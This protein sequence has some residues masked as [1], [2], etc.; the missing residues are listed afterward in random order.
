MDDIHA[1]LKFWFEDIE[2]SKWWIQDTVFDEEIR[3]RFLT[4]HQK[5]TRCEL[6]AWRDTPE[7]AL[8]EI[9][10]LDQFSRNMFRGQPQSFAWDPLA[11]A[12]AQSAIR[13]QYDQELDAAR[14]LFIYMPFMHSESR[15]I[16]AVAK[17]LFAQEGLENNEKFEIEH[18]QII[19]RFGRYPHRNRVLGRQSTPDE[20]EFLHAPIK[21]DY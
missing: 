18:K 17:M 14:R 4:I 10:V 15:E 8:A 6:D 16:H 9:I 13:L 1:I 2:S 3:R 7:G 11:L 12:L 5:A 19:D 21:Q 20:I